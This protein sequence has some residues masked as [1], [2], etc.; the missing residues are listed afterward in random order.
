MT[1][2]QGPV[3]HPYQ[4]SVDELARTRVIWETLCRPSGKIEGTS[5]CQA[6]E[7]LGDHPLAPAMGILNGLRLAV[8]MWGF[9]FLG[10]VLTW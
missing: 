1:P 10:L 8:V 2:V 4:Q 7:E 9:V 3:R 6:D 5:V